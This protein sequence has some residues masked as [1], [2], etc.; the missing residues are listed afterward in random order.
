MMSTPCSD[1]PAV[2]VLS[3][4]PIVTVTIENND[5]EGDDIYFNAGGQGFWIARMAQSLGARTTLCGP[6]GGHTGA[7]AQALILKD[8]LNLRSISISGA[9]GSYVDDRRSGSRGQIAFQQAPKLSRHEVDDLYDAALAE[10]LKAGTLV[11]SGQLGEQVLPAER[12]ASLARDL[13][14]NGVHVIADV[15]GPVLN[16]LSGGLSILKVSHEELID[17]KLAQDDS[18]E[19]IVSAMRRLA[20]G[21]A[22]CIVVSRADQ[23]ALGL[24]D[25]DLYEVQQPAFEAIDTSGAG[26]SMTAGLA[27]S[28]ALGRGAEETLRTAAAAGALNVTRRGR[29]TDSACDIEQVGRLVEVRRCDRPDRA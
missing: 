14:G 18:R 26:D 25:E 7:L 16:A 9:N 19:E 8:G 24:F 29:G 22:E 4:W 12:V 13:H 17:A 28:R 10:G 23:G 2:C 1:A 11:I 15:A 6:F 21:P 3:L 27:V 20:E 5:G